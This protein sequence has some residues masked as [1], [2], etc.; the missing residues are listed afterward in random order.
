MIIR[1]ARWEIEIDPVQTAA[2]YAGTIESNPCQCD[3]CRNFRAAAHL[4]FP[5]AFREFASS[6][7]IDI[8]KPAELCHY[9]SAGEPCPTSG[10]FHL[11]GTLRSGQDAWTETSPN[12]SLLD[13]EP[14]FGLKGI[15]FTTEIALLPDS[16]ENYPVV[17]LEFETM[18]PWILDK[19]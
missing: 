18:V 10:W 14:A 12:T 8:S 17:Q 7:G 1:I 5:E 11:V 2:C 19:Q 15:G 4:A 16:F 9:G 3:D 6:I 13:S